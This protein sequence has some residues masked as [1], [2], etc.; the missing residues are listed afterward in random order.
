[1]QYLKQGNEISRN[2]EKEQEI[3]S[4]LREHGMENY[5]G[6]GSTLS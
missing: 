6:W 5:D 4:Y 1:M 2:N 3:V